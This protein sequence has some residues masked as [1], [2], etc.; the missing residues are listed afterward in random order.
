MSIKTNN[1]I[2]RKNRVRG[3]IR[4]NNKSNLPRLSVFRSNKNFYAQLI[5]D[6]SGDILVSYSSL[7]MDSSKVKDIKG[8]E[9]SKLIGVEF[10]KICNEKKIQK[11]V[12]DKGP[13]LF[14]GRVKNFAD[15]CKSNG[16]EF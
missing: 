11:I 2:R 14:S 6:T 15:S 4:R 13:Y 7:N 3:K 8:V 12:F 16:L 9:I 10:A 1:Y 5:D